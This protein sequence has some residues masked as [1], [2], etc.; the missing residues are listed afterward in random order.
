MIYFFLFGLTQM[1]ETTGLSLQQPAS[2]DTSW[3]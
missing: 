3:A 2:Y 1:I